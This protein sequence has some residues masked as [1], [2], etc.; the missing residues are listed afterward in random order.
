MSLEERAARY[1]PLVAAQMRAAV[2]NSQDELFAWMRYHLG[3]EDREGQPVT[4]SPGKMMRPVGALLATEILGSDVHAALPAAAAIELVHNFS[5]LHDDV[6][7]ASEFRR[8]RQNL[9]TFA[10]APQAIN[11]GDGMF[12]IA[13]LAEYAMTDSAVPAERVLAVMRELDEACLS[14]VRGQYLDMSFETRREVSLEAYVEMAGGKTA[15]MLAAPFAIGALI[16]G[17]PPETVH[18]FRAYGHHVGLAFQMVDDIL[19][20]WGDPQVTGKPVGDDLSSRKMTY[21]VILG[22]SATGEEGE[23]LRSAYATLPSP[24][25]DI[26][27][28][29]RWIAASGAREA[30]EARARGEYEL[31]IAALEGTD[32]DDAAVELLREY[33]S[34]AIGRVT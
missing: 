7:D 6:E 16:A 27:A 8:G 18:A 9:W 24:A 26:A 21:P 22:L 31:A 1:R 13:R 14:L 15:A 5:L 23:A 32:L 12:V 19:G 29:A 4:A 17:A 34:A 30:T 28:M 25:D 3:W 11:T 33:A 20:I 2:G 10:G